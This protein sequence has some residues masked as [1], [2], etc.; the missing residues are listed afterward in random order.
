M[1]QSEA[2]SRTDIPR[3][4]I[5]VSCPDPARPVFI[6][7]PLFYVKET[8][9]F[10]TLA[11]KSVEYRSL[12]LEEFRYLTLEETLAGWVYAVQKRKP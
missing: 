8:I 11:R 3:F 9:V 10:H 4:S 12:A 6:P 7:E 5:V 1:R 2:G